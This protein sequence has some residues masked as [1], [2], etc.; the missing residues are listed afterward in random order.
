MAERGLARAAADGRR[1]MEMLRRLLRRGR[2]GVESCFGATDTGIKRSRNED[3]FKLCPEKGLYVVADGMGGHNAGDVA[4][5]EAVELVCNFFTED[6]VEAMRELPELIPQEL[7]GAIHEAH[8]H[9]VELSRTRPEYVGM[10]TTIMI[11]FIHDRH[12]H[13]SHVG[14]SRA[15]VINRFG[16][17]QLTNDHSSVWEMVRD[18]RMTPEEAR[19]S[20]L[21]NHIS[22]AVGAPFALEPEY[23]REKLFRTDVVLL[24]TD[25]L[26]DML[27]DEEIHSVV[28]SCDGPRQTVTEL[29]RRANEEGGED[30]ITIVAVKMDDNMV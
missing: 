9:I 2:A 23:V 5:A 7:T 4:S 30:N 26:W 21:R 14:D 1:A 16:I 28:M 20:P 25:G 10:G 22:Q 29:I 19:R 24:C 13:V 12:L 6:R 15:Y 18:G 17:T 11:C 8:G 27:S 3:Y